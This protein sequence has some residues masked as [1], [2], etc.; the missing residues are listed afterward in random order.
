MLPKL[1]SLLLLFVVGEATQAAALSTPGAVLE[2]SRQTREFIER[3]RQ[4]QERPRDPEAEV[5]DKTGIEEG[6]ANGG[7]EVR[8]QLRQVV[9]TESAVLSSADLA[10]VAAVYEGREVS[11]AEL[12][13]LVDGVNALYAERKVIAAK[14]VL[15]PQKIE[16]GVVKVRL[17]E[18]QVGAITITGNDNTSEAFVKDR[19]DALA[20]GE[21]V[22]L[23][24][25][26]S[27]LFYFNS[28]NDIDLRAVLKPGETFG[29]T[30]YEVQVIEPPNVDNT[31]FID[32][33]G[34]DDVGLYRL[35]FAHIN[36]SLF[37]YRDSLSIGGNV[38][39]GTMAL[40]AAYNA[41]LNNIGT[42]LGASI[43]YSDIEI[44][45]GPL[46]PLN[47]TG[48][49]VNAGVFLTHPLQVLR[50]GVTNAYF[51]YNAKESNTDF[52]GVTLFTTR[53]RSLTAGVDVQRDQ[54]GSSLFGRATAT[55]APNTWGNSTSFWRANGDLSWVSTLSGGNVLLLRGRAQ[56]S[57]DDLLPSSEQFQVGGMSSVRGYPEGLLIGD[58]GYFGSAEF[59]FPV[60]AADLVD[61]A[62]NP[63]TQRWRGVLFFDHGAAFPFKGNNESINSDDFITSAG[64]GVS[65]NLGKKLQG[66]VL[67]GFPL[68]ERDD[69][70]D[71]PRLH[72]Y[73]QTQAF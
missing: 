73:L 15:P 37:G 32:D 46:D 70:E 27:T 2:G 10:A 43:D 65:I 53:V 8:F 18:G 72:F 29:T 35:G 58:K 40:Y 1:A 39:E 24:A 68:G 5:I 45:D 55:Y 64:G 71:D 60:S 62:S 9:F 22:Y 16:R 50:N 33:A 25:L 20:P 19:L 31:V 26:E 21:L 44:I 14:A 57:P 51:G 54:V 47:V 42:R 48:D 66:R 28:V 63:F 23:D 4:L 12:F 36:R 49:S 69:G 52:D 38:A 67:L 59:T 41:P 61:P 34:R 11:V 13:K 6:P 3:Q 30:D 56:W 17:I 7:S